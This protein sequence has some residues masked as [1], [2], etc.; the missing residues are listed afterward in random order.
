MFLAEGPHAVADALR[1]DGCVVEVLATPAATAAH[2][3]LRAQAPAWTLVDERALA[4]VADSVHPAG[5]VA[6]CRTLGVPLTALGDSL[7]L[8]AV[9]ADVR[10]PGNAGSV[11]RCADAAGADAV[12]LAGDCVDVHN[13]KTVRASAGSVFHLPVALTPTPFDAVAA[14][15]ARQLQVLAADGDGEVDLYAAGALLRRPTGWVFGNE[16][17][18]LPDELARLADHRVAIPI[19]GRAESLNLATAAAVCLYASAYAQRA[20]APGRRS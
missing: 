5:M 8:V 1:V 13:P 6:V 12:V 4:S 17:R 9:C 19:H 20:A 7:R 16:A 11:V 10:D 14:L 2:P 15:R 18:G 3:D